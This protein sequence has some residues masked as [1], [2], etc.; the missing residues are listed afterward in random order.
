MWAG[1]A[2]PGA[3][4]TAADDG[5]AGMDVDGPQ[6]RSTVLAP[7]ERSSVSLPV[8]TT[9]RAGTRTMRST[10]LDGPPPGRP[11]ALL[12]SPPHA[13]RGM[14][15]ELK[16]THS[17]MDLHT[18]SR[19]STSSAN[20]AARPQLSLLPPSTI[21]RQS[22]LRSKLSL[23]NLR[24]KQS[25]ADE[26]SLVSPTSP[27][28]SSHGLSS[29]LGSGLG[30]GMFSGAM[31]DPEMLQVKDMEFELVRPNLVHHFSQAARTSEDSNVLG[32]DGASLDMRHD[33][34]SF[35]MRHEFLRAESPAMSVSSGMD[36]AWVPQAQ[37]QGSTSSSS[38]STLAPPPPASAGESSIEAHRARELKWMALMAASPAAQ[39]RKSKKVRRLLVEGVPSS[40]RYL[41][42]T[43]IADGK[44]R[45]VPGVYTALCARGRVGASGRIAE[46]V[47]AAFAGG[48]EEHLQG[49][50]GGVMSVLSAYLNMVPDVQYAMGEQYFFSIGFSI[51][52]LLLT[53]IVMQASRLSSGN[54]C[55]SRQKRTPS[56]SSYR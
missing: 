26:D 55:S 2:G 48:V 39:A 52:A 11:G 53:D 18:A 43:Y 21:G 29:G 42:W 45:A 30:M 46:D 4:N 37:A 31:H 56:G 28:A 49:T 14:S 47:R 50:R 27:T 12:P 20:D 33:G 7:D 10:T 51:C 16:S 24:R 38:P 15:Q 35:D 41:V 8:P 34:A 19:T 22:S 1:G 9:L 40:V 54:C 13:H 44:A 5:I 6:R 23:P 25:R 32:R 3:G 17:M 36:G